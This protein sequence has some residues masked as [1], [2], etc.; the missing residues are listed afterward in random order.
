MNPTYLDPSNRLH[1]APAEA[2]ECP[3]CGADDTLTPAATPDF[4]ALQQLAPAAT[5]IVFHC[6]DCNTPVFYK[7]RVDSIEPGRVSFGH[8]PELVDSADE[9]FSFRYLPDRV[10]TC[11]R[12]A[13]GCYHHALLHAFGAMCRLTAQAVINDLGEAEQRRMTAQVEEIAELANLDEESYQL[14]VAVLLDP[15]SGLPLAPGVDRRLAG[16]LLECMKDI[17]QQA[18]VRRRRLSKVLKMRQFFADTRAARAMSDE[19]LMNVSTLRMRRPTGT[20]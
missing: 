12:D 13:L 7:F 17:L 2:L 3:H 10:A 4:R 14:I 9:R 11:F 1:G 15:E 6:T 19:S 18:Y 16:I 20:E 8:P 5:G